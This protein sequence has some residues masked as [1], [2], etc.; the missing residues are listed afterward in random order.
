MR[1]SFQVLECEQSRHTMRPCSELEVIV[2]VRR[3]LTIS[4]GF[5]QLQLSGC[6]RTRFHTRS[7]VRARLPSRSEV[8]HG[9]IYW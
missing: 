8:E 9:S 7:N 5:A 6:G 4:T 3:V 2:E 1:C